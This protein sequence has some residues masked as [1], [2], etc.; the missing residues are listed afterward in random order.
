MRH[1][2]RGT[3]RRHDG[4]MPSPR[5]V[6]VLLALDRGFNRVVQLEMA[7]RDELLLAL[8]PRARRDQVTASI[9]A[10]DAAYSAG[11]AFFDNGLFSWEEQLLAHS[12]LPRSGRVLVGG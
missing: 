6:R 3:R 1:V 12:L 4:A 8:V 9:Y 2:A 10:G 11:G 7:L 5:W